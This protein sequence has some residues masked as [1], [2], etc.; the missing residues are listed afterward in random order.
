M[1]GL[2]AN[3]KKKMWFMLVSEFFYY[4]NYYQTS[5][6]LAEPQEQGVNKKR[7]T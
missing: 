1:Q 3:K 6:R 5:K 2:G 7:K 4:C